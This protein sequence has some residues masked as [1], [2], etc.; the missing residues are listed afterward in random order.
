MAPLATYPG[1]LH[2]MS[3]GAKVG[4]KLTLYDF[5]TGEEATIV[6]RRNA[7]GQIVCEIDSRITGTLGFSSLVAAGVVLPNR[8]SH[9][10][11]GERR[12][13][14]ADAVPNR[15]GPTGQNRR[16]CL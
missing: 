3:G 6:R 13:S 5:H 9:M 15:V 4:V 2:A 7:D 8:L 16:R 1:D 14:L 12:G 10:R 11:I